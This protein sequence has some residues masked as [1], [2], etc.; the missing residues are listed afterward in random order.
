MTFTSEICISAFTRKF[1][2][3][4]NGYASQV[5]ARQIK[6]PF[7]VDDTS[8]L[9]TDY[10]F[11]YSTRPEKVDQLLIPCWAMKVANRTSGH[12]VQEPLLTKPWKFNV[13]R[14]SLAYHL[15]S[16][17]VRGLTSTSRIFA[18]PSRK[19]FK[20]PGHWAWLQEHAMDHAG[21]GDH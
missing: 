16:W 12:G 18:T 7:V 5:P 1:Q 11:L 2:L 15:I 3:L 8:V 20:G 13:H 6:D 14:D 19:R 21:N 9:F 10:S 4:H 17:L